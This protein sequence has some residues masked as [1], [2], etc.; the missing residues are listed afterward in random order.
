MGSISWCLSLALLSSP[1]YCNI[2]FLGPFVSYEENDVLW[3]RP[4]TSVMLIWRNMPGPNKILK[5][6]NDIQH[7][8]LRTKGL[9][10]TL[11][12]TWVPLCWVLRFIYCY[13]ECH[14][15]ECRGAFAIASGTK[16]ISF[17]AKIPARSTF[18]SP[19]R[20]KFILVSSKIQFFS[21]W[22]LDDFDYKT[23]DMFSVQECPWI[24][25]LCLQLEFFLSIMSTHFQ[26]RKGFTTVKLFTVVGYSFVRL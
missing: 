1:V 4:L 6:R 25:L 12:I 18:V 24:F 14:Y 22:A 15:T 7:T 5:R 2:S 3:I 19:P 23:L 13:A 16:K 17:M 10:A 26:Q 8:T 11:S 9:F 21:V 20:L